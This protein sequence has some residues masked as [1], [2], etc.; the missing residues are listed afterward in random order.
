MPAGQTRGTAVQ[1]TSENQQ[2]NLFGSGAGQVAARLMFLPSAIASD[3]GAMPVI[4]NRAFLAATASATGD[5]ITVGVDG[6]SQR[7]S[8]AGVVDAFPTTDPERPLLIVD[9]PTLGLLRLQANGIARSADEWWIQAADGRQDALAAALRDSPFDSA[10]VVSAVGRSRS[11][12]TDPVAIGIIGALALGFVATGLFAIVGL[13]VSCRRLGAGAAH[14][15]RAVARA[16]PV[17]AAA[18]GL[19][20]A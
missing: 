7:I 15:V 19:A 12:S 11:L 13:T 18:V 5:T 17:G 4:A 1:I 8:I 16:G 20:V 14:R 3:D 10:Q 6:A 9:E 2:G